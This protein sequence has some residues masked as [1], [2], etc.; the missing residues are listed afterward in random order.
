VKKKEWLQFLEKYQIDEEDFEA[1]GLEWDDL[2]TIRDEYAAIRPGLEPTGN[3]IASC[4]RQVEAV[5]SLKIRLK[6]PEHLVAKYI[7]A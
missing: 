2:M 3:Y 6:N 5:H 1:T 4:L 7:G